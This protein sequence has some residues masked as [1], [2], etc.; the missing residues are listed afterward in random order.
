MLIPGLACKNEI[1]GW[2]LEGQMPLP[3]AS[4]WVWILR[5]LYS[6]FIMKRRGFY[7]LVVWAVFN[8]K[9]SMHVS[10][11]SR[12]PFLGSQHVL[13]TVFSSSTLLS[14]AS[15]FPHPNRNLTPLSFFFSSIF[16]WSLSAFVLRIQ[17][18]LPH[19]V[20]LPLL[21]CWQVFLIHIV[22]LILIKSLS[23]SAKVDV[24]NK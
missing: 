6:L 9:S 5:L 18:I 20:I 8:A 17:I 13:I 3:I 24:A 19:L 16:S 2:V 15:Q 14:G 11:K 22:N 1:N 23:L 10:K 12:A 4:Y 7:G 21:M